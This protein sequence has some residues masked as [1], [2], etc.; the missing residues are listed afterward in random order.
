MSSNLEQELS[1]ACRKGTI[2]DV[3]DLLERGAKP[4]LSLHTSDYP[5]VTAYKNKRMDVVRLLLDYD[6]D[7]NLHQ[8]MDSPLLSLAC[9]RGSAA[10]VMLFLNHGAN[11]N[12]ENNE[13][14][15]ETPL[16]R[17][18]L[19]GN[20]EVVRVLLSN[21]ADVNRAGAENNSPLHRAVM[22]WGIKEE[23][24]DEGIEVIRMLLS[25]GADVN[26]PKND[27]GDTPMTI[28]FKKDRPDVMLLFM[29][30]G[31]VANEVE[32]N[33]FCERYGMLEEYA[34]ICAKGHSPISADAEA[35]DVVAL[36]R[37]SSRTPSD[38][39]DSADIIPVIPAQEYYLRN[40]MDGPQWVRGTAPVL[41]VADTGIEGVRL[42]K[43]SPPRYTRRRSR[44]RGR[45]RSRSRSRS[46]SRRGRSRSGSR[47][48]SG[49]RSH[50]KHK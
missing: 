46:R 10:D 16:H 2:T 32:M 43:R 38:I 13:H 4:N 7:V 11:V 29:E 50:K 35:V 34:E 33:A 15:H 44:S 14:E 28:A 6:A 48:W 26:A 40:T 37:L 20:A 17:A 42:E 3:K 9:G 19:S 8:E 18:V 5:L 21:G 12:I 36:A 41:R 47:S 27:N 49:S 39:E 24:K 30:N 25:N 31:Y 22:G 23:I 1:F 45:G